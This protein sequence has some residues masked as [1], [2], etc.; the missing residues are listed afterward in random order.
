[1]NQN[2][3]ATQR[4][5]EPTKKQDNEAYFV[6]RLYYQGF[7][8]HL[9]QPLRDALKEGKDEFKLKYQGESK[10]LYGKNRD[11]DYELNFKKDP[12]K[13]DEKGQAIYYFN[14]MKATL[15]DEQDPKKDRSHL[16]YMDNDRGVSTKE[17]FNMLEERAVKKTLIKHKRDEKGNIVRTP[18]EKPETYQAWLQLDLGKRKNEN[19][20]EMAKY[21]EN[22]RYDLNK[23]ISRFDVKGMEHEA[24]KST[25]I[26]SLEKGNPT[27]V[28]FNGKEESNGFLVANPKDKNVVAYDSKWEPFGHG[29]RQ[30]TGEGK[31]K[32]EEQN[33]GKM[34]SH[35]PSVRTDGQSTGKGIEQGPSSEVKGSTELKT[36]NEVSKKQHKESNNQAAENDSKKNRKSKGVGV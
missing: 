4:V 10:G 16:F 34:N 8:N 6:N 12:V 35:E 21:H 13:K 24:T 28:V 32:T 25:I 23:A 14:S 5:A 36:S 29:M 18:G 26:K 19:E 3:Q 31:D 30:R 17:A 20:Y 9:S 22:Y 11:I 15:R 7:D 2:E 1:M 27:F 33:K